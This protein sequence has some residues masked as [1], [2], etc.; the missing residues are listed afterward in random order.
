[1]NYPQALAWLDRIRRAGD[2][3]GLERI[4]SLLRELGDPQE[5]LRFI[6]IT[7]TNG[8]GSVLAFLDSVLQ[9]AGCRTGRYVSPAL[10]S[11]EERFLCC[12]SPISRDEFAALTEEMADACA[13]M[14]ARGETLPTIFEVETAMAFSWFVKKGCD[15][16]LLEIGMGGALDATNIV[17]RTLLC[18]FTPITLDHMQYLGDTPEKIAGVK[19]GILKPGAAALSAPQLPGVRRVLEEEA[20]RLGV[21][22]GFLSPGDLSDVRPGLE[23]QRFSFGDPASPGFLADLLI[24]LPGTHQ[25]ENAALAA[26]AAL[27]LAGRG[28]NIPESAIRQGLAGAVWPGRL[29][30]ICKE[31]LVLI[32]GAHNPDAARALM[33]SVRT[34][35]PGKRLFYVFGMFADKDRGEVI[36]LT[37]PAA[38]HI[39]TVETPRSPR[40]YPAEQ[41]AKEVAAVNPHVTTAGAPEAGLRMALAAAGPEDVILAFGSL[42][43]LRNIR[44][45]MEHQAYL[46]AEALLSSGSWSQASAGLGRIRELMERLSDPQKRL[47]IVH[48][49]G[50]NGKGSTCAMLAE[51]L[52][53]AGYKTG[54]SISPHL[55]TVRERFCINGE[56]ISEAV[57]AEA[58]SV[59][60]DA[61][62]GMADPPT[63][64]ELYTALALCWFAREKCD[65]VV[66]ETG[67]GG[68]LDS[69]NVIDPPLACVITSIG[70]DHTQYLGDTLPAIAREKAGI[71]KPGSVLVCAP[72]PEEVLDVFREACREKQVPLSAA[73]PVSA[74]PGEA[75]LSGQSFLWNGSVYRLRLLGDHQLENASLVLETVRVL[76]EVGLDIPEDAV[77]EGLETIV[78]PARFEVLS[79]DPV[80]ILDGAH[81]PQG[82]AAAASALA[83]WLPGKK[84]HFLTGML[85]DKACAEFIRTLVPIAA[86][87]T[88]IPA[89]GPRGLSAEELNAIILEETGGCAEI[90]VR[91]CENAGEGVAL[92]ISSGSFPAMALGSFSIAAGVRE[93]AGNSGLPSP[94]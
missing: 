90:P 42:S 55:E 89:P 92:L 80:F 24:R 50:T 56:M 5:K 37:A 22:I 49:A 32:D 17:T 46:R 20:A 28:L 72:G 7:G 3:P 86:S 91:T 45:E 63:R 11:Y 87:F 71:I 78:W 75:S 4:R 23:E 60:L 13:R 57:F 82:A 70:F 47:R 9:E 14:E 69:T 59:L 40:A 1:M 79:D 53:R 29:E 77:R 38:Q 93:A 74:V 61:A 18:L 6:H 34:L 19:A 58:V 62:R 84:I 51:I 88:C 36:R 30:V 76:R 81:N 8:K 85:R 12:G 35:F 67:M 44:E 27:S 66:L 33:E 83:K 48:V 25:I 73:E 41:L 52:R 10:F 31:P 26:A 43:F 65:I 68:K 16:V 2:C 15:P 21:K 64:F 54:L 39:Y 94:R